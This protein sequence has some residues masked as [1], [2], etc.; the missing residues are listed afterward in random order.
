MLQQL[1]HTTL[2]EHPVVCSMCARRSC[3]DCK[4]R[5]VCVCVCVWV[6]VCVCVRVC[7]CVFCVCVCVL[8][9]CVRVCHTHVYTRTHSS[10]TLTVLNERGY[11]CHNSNNVFVVFVGSHGVG[12]HSRIL[13]H[14][15]HKLIVLLMCC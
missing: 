5:C 6:C 14:H 1:E 4:S 12:A 3:K 11:V 15:Y 13:T 10:R 8:C 9:A 2:L 7:V